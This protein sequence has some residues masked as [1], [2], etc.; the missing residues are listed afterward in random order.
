M[1]SCHSSLVSTA[2]PSITEIYSICFQ[3]STTDLPFIMWIENMIC[4]DDILSSN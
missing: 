3:S 2:G 4:V 1:F